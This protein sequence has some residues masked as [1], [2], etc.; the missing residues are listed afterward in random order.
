MSS[1]QTMDCLP[2]PSGADCATALNLPQFEYC[3]TLHGY[4]YIPYFHLGT[5][6]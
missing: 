2:L 5:L 4:A 1:A 6:C 3:A